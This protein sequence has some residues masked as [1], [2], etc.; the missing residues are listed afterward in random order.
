MHSPVPARPDPEGT[1]RGPSCL[2]GRGISATPR[3]AGPSSRPLPPGVHGEGLAG[4]RPV[5]DQPR[6]RGGQPM[7]TS[8]RVIQWQTL[9][10]FTAL[11]LAPA[12]LASWPDR[13]GAGEVDAPTNVLLI[14]A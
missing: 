1:R 5:S 11:L 10:S 14:L 7:R 6:R 12:W 9:C 3:I 2:A 13:A 8:N 4:Y